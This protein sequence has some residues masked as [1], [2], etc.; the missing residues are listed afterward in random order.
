MQAK[1]KDRILKNTVVLFAGQLTTW[2]LTIVFSIYVARRVGTY[3]W[4]ELTIAWGWTTIASTLAALGIGTLMV[5]DMARDHSKVPAM[6][7]VA[8]MT[9]IVL[10]LPCLAAIV[11][12]AWVVYPNSPHVQLVIDI[13]SLGMVI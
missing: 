2:A 10:A 9:R 5:R 13:L 7:G 12:L 11:A 6:V 3:G 4:G 8:L 1:A